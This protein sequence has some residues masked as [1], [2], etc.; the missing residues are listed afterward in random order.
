LEVQPELRRHLEKAPQPQ[1]GVRRNG[2]FPLTISLMR[3]GGTRGLW[4]AG[5]ALSHW[6]QKFFLED[7]SRR[8]IRKQLAFH[9]Q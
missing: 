9:G 3:R 5:I 1:G 2:P 8:D 4:P 6:L 7:F